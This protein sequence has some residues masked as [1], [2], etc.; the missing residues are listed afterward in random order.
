MRNEQSWKPSKYVYRRNGLSA[1]RDKT[2]VSAG[3]VLITDIVAKIYEQNLPQHATGRLLDLGCGKAPLYH[4][5]RNLIKSSTCV[6]WVNTLHKNEYL[7]CECD[8]T[9]EL[10][11]PDVSFDTVLL[12]DVL[13]HIPQPELLCREI[14]R[15][16]APGGKLIMNVP[17]YYWLHERPHDYH[18]YTEFALRRLMTISG[19]TLLKVESIGGA[20]EII[21][22]IVAKCALRLP[23]GGEALARSVQWVAGRFLRSR[24]GRR[25]SVASGA[26]F[27]F[28]YFLVAQKTEYSLID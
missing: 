14:A 10:P 18:R 28:G 12:S 26:D 1:S 2:E 27:P 5:Y 7:D 22:D 13:E 25:I 19:L 16:L 23:K 4:A 3:S 6:D 9:V 8:L 17:F 21:A 15:M 11:F 24:L 20:P